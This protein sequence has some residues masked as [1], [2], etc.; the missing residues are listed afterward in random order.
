ME[1]GLWGMG[2]LGLGL[3]WVCEGVLE[4]G[5]KGMVVVNELHPETV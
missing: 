4:Y 2:D 1:G 3:G 5:E